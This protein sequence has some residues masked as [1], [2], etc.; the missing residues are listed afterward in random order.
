MFYNSVAYDANGG[1]GA[2]ENDYY[3]NGN[4][5]IVSSVVPSKEG[6]LF[7]GWKDEDGN[8]YQVNDVITNKIS[9]AYKYNN[10][11]EGDKRC[12]RYRKK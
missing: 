5:A 4:P 7:K 11:R 3:Y 9:K 12:V 2:P 10:T 8:I 6:Y 1:T